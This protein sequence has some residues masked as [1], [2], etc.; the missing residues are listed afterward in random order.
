MSVGTEQAQNGPA[1]LDVIDQAKH[2]KQSWL[3][4][5]GDLDEVEV[6]VEAIG[7]SVVVR[8]LT[9]GQLARIQDEC[10]SMKGDTVKVDSLRMGVLKFARAVI[11]PQFTED[12]ANV[13]AHKYG[14]SFSLVVGVVDDIS[15]AGEEDVAKARR[16]FRPRR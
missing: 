3:S 12:E 16:R 11:E 14:A 1:P 6:E 7:D 2:D 13:I 5:P 9:A 10:M 15:K 8:S 4:G